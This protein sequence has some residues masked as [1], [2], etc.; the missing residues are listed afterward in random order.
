MW[1]RYLQPCWLTYRKCSKPLSKLWVHNLLK[2]NLDTHRRCIIHLQLSS[3]SRQAMSA[4]PR[5]ARR[6]SIPHQLRPITKVL[7]NRWQISSKIRWGR[8]IGMDGD[9]WKSHGQKDP[10]EAAPK[11]YPISLPTSIADQRCTISVAYACWCAKNKCVTHNWQTHAN[12]LEDKTY[13]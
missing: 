2:S 8:N 6:L 11:G 3:S 5:N 7:D 10:C 13:R 9:S 12:I 4:W 1:Q